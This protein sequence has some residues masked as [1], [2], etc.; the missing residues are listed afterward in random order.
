MEAI[1]Y[2]FSIALKPINL[3][4]S[5]LGVSLGTLVGVLPGL[6]PVA[7][8]SLLLPTTFYINPESAFIMLAGVYYGS[9]YGGSTTSILANIP[10]EAAS[11]V[12]CLDGY[13]MALQGRAG[14]ALGISAFGSFIGGT[15]SVVGLMVAAPPL[16]LIALKF[17]PPEYFS[18]MVLGLTILAYLSS[19]S[20]IKAIMMAAFGI[21]LG[22]VGMDTIS[23]LN[24]FT[25]GQPAL[26]DGLGIVPVA[27]GLFGVSEVLLNVEGPFERS[28]LVKRLK[29]ILPNLQDWKDSIGAIFRGTLVG[30][31]LGILP[32]GGTIIS[33]F[34]SYALEKRVSRHPDRFG[35]GAIQGVA[36]PET[37]NNAATG[38]AFIPMLAL[39][40]PAN[41][42]MA[43][44]LG[45]LMIHGLQTGPLLIKEAPNIFWGTIASM[46]IGNLFLLVLN[47][48]LIG[49]W[50]KILHIPYRILFP[51][52]LLF[53]LIGS[54]SLR[55]NTI[56]V[57]IM[58][59]FG[60][61]GYLTKKFRYE[62][63]PLVL[64]MILGPMLESALRQSLILSNGSFHI[65]FARPLSAMLMGLS[66]FLLLSP[67][68]MRKRPAAGLK[69]PD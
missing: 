9:M 67:I 24:R 19:G 33:S 22:S 3:A 61:I 44:L 8:I 37:A 51:L 2:G 30:F 18:L 48:P 58:V 52:I 15:L 12:T 66:A 28:A 54:Y 49:L 38:A 27:M 46:Y 32:G 45:A 23:G 43:V 62:C 55:N 42:V 16:V 11:V 64:A 47:L 13:Q 50:V 65:F 17:G 5:F 10:G 41:A 20:M 29:G 36:A 6:G 40:I 69:E 34:A 25:Y 26:I 53:T 57:G 60:L 7:T 68:L 63:A 39:G 31:F 35:K 1:F 4:Y 56:D 21:M 59:I 14:P